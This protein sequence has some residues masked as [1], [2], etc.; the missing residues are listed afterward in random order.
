MSSNNPVTPKDLLTAV[1]TQI[2]RLPENEYWEFIRKCRKDYESKM[3]AYR[4]EHPEF[5]KEE[6]N[7]N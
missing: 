6:N 3:E 7:N 2:S 1:V 4:K 5:H